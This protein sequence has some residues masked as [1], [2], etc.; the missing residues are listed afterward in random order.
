M[1]WPKIIILKC[2]LLLLY[3][4]TM[5]HF[6]TGLWHAT[7]SGFYMTSSD[8]QLSGWTKKE[9]QSTFQSQTCTKKCSWSL[10]GGL[11]PVWSTTAFW[12]PAKPLHLSSMLNNLMR[13]T[14]NC[15]TRSPHWSTEWT[16]LF[17]MTTCDHTSYNECFK[18]WTNWTTKFCLICHI[19]LPLAN[20][21]HFSKHLDN[22]LQGKC[23][24]IQQ[25][26]ENV[27]QEIIKS[28]SM[29]FYTTGINELVSH[30]QKCVDCNG[31]YFD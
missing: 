2:R 28:Q 8:D 20:Q 25:E 17:S 4:I 7:K 23:F 24:Y 11:L 22:L 10:I 3:I 18:S 12:I 1:G 13:C 14:E 30:W 9:L 6:S 29:D 26:A 15:N 16:Q 31:S 27:F 21:L 5:N 19:H